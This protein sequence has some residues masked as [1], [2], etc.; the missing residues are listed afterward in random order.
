MD[1]LDRPVGY[2]DVVTALRALESFDYVGLTETLSETLAALT[3]AG[4]VS[5]RLDN[6][7]HR[8]ESLSHEVVNLDDPAIRDFYCE[9]VRWDAFLY[10]Q[11]TKQERAI[12]DNFLE[13]MPR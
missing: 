7:P 9:A 4:G 13:T 1:Y 10:T 11:A 12:R 6:I 3:R 8:N 2:G 5:L